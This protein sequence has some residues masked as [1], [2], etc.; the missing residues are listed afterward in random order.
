MYILFLRK[1]CLS[2]DSSVCFDW[3]LFYDRK[4]SKQKI[5]NSC[6]LANMNCYGIEFIDCDYLFNL[7]NFMGV[8]QS[9]FPFSQRAYWFVSDYL[10]LILVSP[11]LNI[12][13]EKMINRE[14]CYLTVLLV[15]I[16]CILP[17]ISINSWDK[18]NL[19]MFITLFFIAALIKKN[20]TSVKNKMKIWMLLW[21]L[22]IVLLV[23]SGESVYL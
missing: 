4:T 11:F 14:L 19:L 21:L 23:T 18:G 9:V 2:C 17:Y 10:I 6:V 5:H 20:E 3:Q 12:L 13:L 15:V 22:M 1:R 16:T 8:L 7:W